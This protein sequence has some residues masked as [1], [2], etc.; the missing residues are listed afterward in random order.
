M[1][2]KGNITRRRALL[3]GGG[4]LA[5]GGGATYVASRSGSGEQRY[6]PATSHASTASTGFGLEL[7]G[8]P[9][10]GDSEAVVDIY[11]WTDYLCPF[12]KKFETETFP[13]IGRNYLDT[14]DARLVVLSYPNIGQYSMS[15]AVWGRCVWSQV[16]DNS[17]DT[18]W[19]WH[20]AAFDEQPDSGT[21]WADD[22]TF[23]QVT[24]ETDGVDV[25]AVETCR[26][27]RGDSIRES[28]EPNLG[29]ARE[30]GIQGTPGFV[31]YNRES[32]AAGRIVGAHPYQN[33]ADAIDQVMES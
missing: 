19:N 22:E 9:I 11:Y 30:A 16:A 6:V 31:I 4:I 13:E 12:C 3:A 28:M 27:Q 1:D 15:A 21:D 7:A 5:F 10:A 18:F 23:T 14:G 25:S 33:F 32:E 29:L 26:E 8:R 17:P 20:S 24:E 2:K